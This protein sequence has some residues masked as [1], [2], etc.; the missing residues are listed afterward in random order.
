VENSR[1]NAQSILRALAQFGMGSPGLSEEDFLEPDQIV[2]IGYPPERIDILTAVSGLVFLD[3]YEKRVIIPLD[4][5]E[6]N[7][8]DLENLKKNK[9][10]SGRMQDLVDLENLQ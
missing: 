10:A 7:F 3:C 1:E 5:V 9:K 2:Q 8:I 4:D 6:V